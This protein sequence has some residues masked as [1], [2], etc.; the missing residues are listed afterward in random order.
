VAYVIVVRKN[1]ASLEEEDQAVGDQD[2]EKGSSP[3]LPSWIGDRQNSDYGGD[4]ILFITFVF[5]VPKAALIKQDGPFQ[6][7]EEKL[8]N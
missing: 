1:I 8:W 3:P 7:W 2:W 5:V 4:A 6:V